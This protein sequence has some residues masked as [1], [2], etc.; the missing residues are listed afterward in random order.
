MA[1]ENVIKEYIIKNHKSIRNFCIT[2]GLKYT[3][4]ISVLS[5]GIGNASFSIVAEIAHALGLEA[6]DLTSEENF[7][8]AIK[9]GLTKD[10]FLE[11]I[12]NDP[13]LRM[14]AKIRGDL[15]A[16]GKKDLLKYAELLRNQ[17]NSLGVD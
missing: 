8:E 4:V 13:E 14:V 16:D 2:K 5:R 6:D 10:L 9:K 17:K 3:T 15:T 7:T 1:I 12:K 11:M